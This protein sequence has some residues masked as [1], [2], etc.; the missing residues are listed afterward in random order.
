M[1]KL[2]QT[3]RH[4]IACGIVYATAA[5]SY[6]LW[7]LAMW[8]REELHD[9]PWIYLAKLGSHGS[10]TLMCWAFLLATRFRPIEWLFG[11]LDKVYR[12]HRIIGESAFFLILLHPLFLA[13]ARAEEAGG[14]LPY[15]WFSSDWARNT[16]IVA[17]VAFVVLVALSIYWKI[18]Y[19]RWKRSHDFFGALLVL[20]VIHAVLARGE[21]LRYPELALWHGAWVATGLAAFVYIRGLYR[22]VGPQYDYAVSSAAEVGDQITEVHL[23]P[24][25]R[26]LDHAPGQFVYISFD[27]DAVSEE[28]HPFSISSP[29]GAR[30]LRLSIKRLGDWTNDIDRIRP[31]ERA[32]VWGPYGHFGDI[33]RQRPELP[34][35]MIGGGI[36]IT[37]VLSIAGSDLLERREGL[38]T[39]VYAVPDEGSLVYDAELSARA[40]E[41]PNVTYRRHLSD[42]EGYIDQAYLES[43][44]QRPLPDHLFLVCGPGPMMRA[45]RNLF[46]AAGVRPTRVIMED[47]AIRD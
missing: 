32:R 34:A 43:L 17:M 5:A 2:H 25:G 27:S 36:G 33:L 26:R 20:V 15:L 6:L 37:P 23:D 8:R 12:A 44:L 4:W 16:G 19:H 31:G 9:S 21:I 1:P 24:A 22:F 47:F 28:P 14:F 11:G 18:A 13:V 35:V 42:R 10:L 29:P 3:R 38:A 46:R 40:A 45:M 41:L 39:I 7:I 30:S